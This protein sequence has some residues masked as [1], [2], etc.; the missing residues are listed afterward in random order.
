MERCP[1][2]ILRWYLSSVV[3]SA[4]CWSFL[5]AGALLLG[6][7]GGVRGQTGLS[8]AVLLAAGAVMLALHVVWEQSAGG[9]FLDWR[10]PWADVASWCFM[11][12]LTVAWSL[13]EGWPGGGGWLLAWSV[14]FFGAFWS[15]ERRVR[16]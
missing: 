14:Y 16:F 8:G 9:R 10:G 2:P 7:S 3:W 4:V 13:V 12:A 15:V 1:R 5:V 11:I 6:V